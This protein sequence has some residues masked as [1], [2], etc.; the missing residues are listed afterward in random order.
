MITL[1]DWAI[2]NEPEILE[3]WDYEKNRDIDIKKIASHSSKKAFWR[4]PKHKHSY[5]AR[6]G[7]RVQ[8]HKC[9]YCTNRAV[10]EGFNDLQSQYPDIA[11]DFDEEK[12]GFCAKNITYGSTKKI[13]WKCHV[14]GCEWITSAAR[15][16][17]NNAKCPVC[18]KKQS[19]AKRR[20][21]QVKKR[22]DS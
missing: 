21:S 2:I 10:L 13:Y 17:R 5:S 8:G 20:I 22:G 3:E 11:L 4:C 14:C 1:Y 15:R 19:I 6:I 12:N 9:I 16:T 18:V 7:K